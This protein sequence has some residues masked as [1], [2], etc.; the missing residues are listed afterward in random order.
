MIIKRRKLYSKAGNILAGIGTLGSAGLILG[1][2]GGAKRGIKKAGKEEKEEAAKR[3]IEENKKQIK[4]N[5]KNLP[6]YK[7]MAKKEREKL[8]PK[9]SWDDYDR[10][11]MEV[12]DSVWE[13]IPK[14]NKR[15][16]E[17]NKEL[18][19]GN[20]NSILADETP[21]GKKHLRRGAILGTGSGIALG[22]LAGHLVNKIKR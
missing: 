14:E 4:E 11:Q 17:E 20:Y 9:D 1:T 15:L 6:R 2:I 3:K 21:T 8:G 7:E 5:N 13:D 19:S 16:K 22:A 18:K 12:W 10:A